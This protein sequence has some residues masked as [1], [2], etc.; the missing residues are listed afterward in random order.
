M[1]EGCEISSSLQTDPSD[2]FTDEQDKRLRKK[3]R[4]K[5]EYFKWREIFTIL[6]PE[7]DPQ[8][9]PSPCEY[10]EMYSVKIK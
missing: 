2:G 7:V 3:Q 9:I 6:F 4:G 10:D 5:L 1:L 8:E